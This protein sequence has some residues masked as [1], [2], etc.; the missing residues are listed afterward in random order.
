M[1]NVL[2]LP[3]QC[4]FT[5]PPGRKEQSSGVG[6]IFIRASYPAFIR[7]S[8]R[9]LY[10]NCLPTT[11][12]NIISSADYGNARELAIPRLEVRGRYCKPN[13]L[14]VRGLYCKPNKE[15]LWSEKARPERKAHAF[16]YFNI[17]H[18]PRGKKARADALAWLAASVRRWTHKY[19]TVFE[20]RILPPLDTYE[21]LAD[22]HLWSPCGMQS[23]SVRIRV[24]EVGIQDWRYPLSSTLSNMADDPK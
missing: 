10:S 16:T 19:N 2:F 9:S 5:V 12:R 11:L 13:R 24:D 14:E 20:R 21:A 18:V 3:G 4:T 8:Y 23:S 17:E 7:A 15:C 1:G 6:I 22:R